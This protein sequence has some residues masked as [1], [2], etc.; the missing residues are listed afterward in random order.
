DRRAR[1]ARSGAM[2]RIYLALAAAVVVAAVIGLVILLRADDAP[3]TE[4]TATP[5]PAPAPS[6]AAKPGERRLAPVPSPPS[7]PP[8]ADP[9]VRDHRTHDDSAAEPAPIEPPPVVT[10]PPADRQRTEITRGLSQ[11]LQPALQECAANL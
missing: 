10:P 3:I 4:R 2:N 9:T 7:A 8:A 1:R 11:K 5:A 6:V